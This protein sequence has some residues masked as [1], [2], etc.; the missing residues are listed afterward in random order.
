VG[1]IYLVSSCVDLGVTNCKMNL[2]YGGAGA[3]GSAGASGLA[4]SGYS[5]GRVGLEVAV[6]FL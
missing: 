2:L 4:L 6:G 1:G 5:G 3:A